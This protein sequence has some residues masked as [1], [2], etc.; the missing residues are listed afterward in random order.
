[1]QSRVKLGV[2][3]A[4]LICMLLSG[5][6][7]LAEEPGA[8]VKSA[9]GGSMIERLQNLKTQ[10]SEH[11]DAPGALGA[12]RPEAMAG[13]ESSGMGSRLVQ[14]LVLALGLFFI[15]LHFLKRSGR[16]KLHSSGKH[17]QLLERL[18]LSSKTCLNLV[19]VDGQPFLVGVGPDRVSIMPHRGGSFKSLMREEP[20]LTAKSSDKLA[21]K[22]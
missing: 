11:N 16:V 5:R 14:G 6:T 20:A 18:P 9:Q 7:L 3:W 17:M 21:A 1:M 2:V 13:S 4:I 12:W 19:E 10:N 22:A 8:Q 15:L